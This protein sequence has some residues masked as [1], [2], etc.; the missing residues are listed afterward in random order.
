MRRDLIS[1]KHRVCPSVRGCLGGFSLIWTKL[2]NHFWPVYHIKRWDLRKQTNTLARLGSRLS[3]A[4]VDNS[5]S[6]QSDSALL[7][8]L[9]PLTFTRVLR[10]NSLAIFPPF[11]YVQPF[12]P[13]TQRCVFVLC[14]FVVV[15]GS[16]AP[17]PF[18]IKPGSITQYRFYNRGK[19]QAFRDQNPSA[20]L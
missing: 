12:N 8:A 1:S 17:H 15:R 4:L 18:S 11:L 2:P 7:R 10:T 3:R 20:N 6:L 5:S 9:S 13:L 16:K 14:L 19:G